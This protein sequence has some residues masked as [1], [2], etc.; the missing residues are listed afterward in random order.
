MPKT[1]TSEAA[2]AVAGAEPVEIAP[3]VVTRVADA[4]EEIE[5]EG[6]GVKRV[7]AGYVIVETADGVDAYPPEAFAEAYP[8]I[9]L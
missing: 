7:E 4:Y 9:A 8:G 3:G 2:V 5:V 6:G 1:K